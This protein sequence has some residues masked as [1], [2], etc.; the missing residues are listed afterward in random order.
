MISWLNGW[1]QGIIVAVIIATIIEML[2][3]QGTIKKYIKV[4]IGVY[5][6]FTIISPIISKFKGENYYENVISETSKYALEIENSNN[7]VAKEME[8]S[9][10]KTIKDIFTQNLE[11]D[12]KNKLKAKEYRVTKLSIKVK[13][14]EQY[15]IEKIN[16]SVSK[17]KK[18]NTEKTNTIEITI[19][20]VNIG[21]SI[22]EVTS[23]EV[24]E[25]DKTELKKFLQETYGI[26][27][28]SIIID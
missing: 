6:L 7:K 15:D 3:P 14:D 17:L 9:S 2:I 11:E 20:E 10:S 18:E 1:V 13:G 26:K 22:T 16:L 19:N 12:I 24:S 21:N 23:G 28:E 4:V 25:Q 8:D 27:S 5:I